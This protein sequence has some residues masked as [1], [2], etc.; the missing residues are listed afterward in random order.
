[1]PFHTSI[2][3]PLG[4]TICLWHLT[5]KS[6]ELF[7]LL[8]EKEREAFGTMEVLEKRLCERAATRLLLEAMEETRGAQLGY[9]PEGAP[10]L[11][12]REGFISISHTRGWVAVAYHPK[13][14]IGLDVECR[15][16]QVLRVAPRVL[17]EKELGF[18]PTSSLRSVW[19]HLCWSGKEAL[20][21]AIP[22]SEID[23]REQLHIKPRIPKEE[24]IL[25]AT[26]TRTEAGGEYRLWYRVCDEFVI[27]CAV[28]TIA[29]L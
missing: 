19:L 20:F 21:K 9:T 1:M 4:A 23:F 2:L 18:L 5:E 7:R 12:N 10:Y 27:V 22:E 28:P 17:N 15:G 8:P 26:E 6:E 13:S 14:P 11:L 24:G 25:L 29:R 3:T 16:E